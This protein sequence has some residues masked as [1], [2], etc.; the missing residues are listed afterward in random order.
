MS[1]LPVGQYYPGNSVFY[2]IDARAK[3]VCLVVL[4][5]AIVG[6]G[7]AAG[8]AVVCALVA[9]IV[10]A[11]GL[12][13]RVATGSLLRI[14]RFLIVIF[15]MN[16]LFFGS[17]RPILRFWICTLSV[18]GMLQGVRVAVSVALLMILG[19]VLLCTT[20]PV[21]IT[22]ALSS[23]LAPLSFVGVPVADVAMIITVA[24]RF[25]PTLMEETE[26]IRLA[27]TARGARFDSRRLTDRAKAVLPLVVPI[28]ISAFKRADDLAQAME[29]RGY[30]GA[31]GRTVYRR[32]P[33]GRRDMLAVAL[34]LAVCTAQLAAFH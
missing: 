14:W 24:I 23:L 22:G 33:L 28:F 32:G 18:E 20:R 8:Y 6:T 15:L 21:E 1:R 27:Q 25:I 30:R 31:A 4:L 12:P 17:S 10:W 16:A 9:A 19:N 2:R 7:D 11:S 26:T 3:L 34:C 5:A 13:V 29:A